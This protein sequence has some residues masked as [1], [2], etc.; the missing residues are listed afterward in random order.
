MFF[1]GKYRS[2]EISASIRRGNIGDI[3]K[4]A[5]LLRLA[6]MNKQTIAPFTSS[7]EISV[8]EAYRIQLHQ[9]QD[10]TETV[11][12]VVGMKIGLTSK[13]MQDMF[14]VKTPDFGHILN[15]MVY[16]EEEPINIEQFLQPKLNSN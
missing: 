4:G 3:Q 1:A 13:A 6:E 10:K 15:T 11:A 16:T 2:L 14:K 7:T 9:I 5:Q 8:D 12:E